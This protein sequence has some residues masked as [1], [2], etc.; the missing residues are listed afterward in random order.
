VLEETGDSFY[1][2]IEY[3]VT[4]ESGAAKD[5]TFF[6]MV[7]EDSSGQRY[8]LNDAATTWGKYG[9][10]NRI[11]NGG[12]I[13]TGSAGYQVPRNMPSP[14][15][16]IVRSDATSANSTRFSVS[17]AP[18]QPGPPQP[19]VELSQVFD[20]VTRNVIVING[21]LYNDGE[22]P[23]VVTL[24]NIN[25]TYSG[26]SSSMQASTPLLPWNVAAD[27]YQEFE[28]QFSRPTGVDSVLLEILGFTFRI[29]GLE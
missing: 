28:L 1:F 17:Y 15:T 8:T 2:V 16:W 14:A 19:D 12:E 7:L 24:A 21:T 18:P 5:A 27:D 4:N 6:D 26:G 25:L 20:D 13:A 23:L 29:E 3:Q 10:L 22:S 9:R 11:L